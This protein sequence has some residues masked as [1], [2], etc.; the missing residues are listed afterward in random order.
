MRLKR[1]RYNLASKQQQMRFFI[2]EHQDPPIVVEA[3]VTYLT[4]WLK[5]VLSYLHSFFTKL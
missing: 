2:D 5:H 3:Q 1:V 4:H